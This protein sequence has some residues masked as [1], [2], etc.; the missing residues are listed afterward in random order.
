MGGVIQYYIRRL[1]PMFFLFMTEEA[2]LRVFLVLREFRQ[3]KKDAGEVFL[4]FATG[5]LFDAGIFAC[6][7]IPLAAY[8]AALPWRLHGTR[9]DRLL[10]GGLYFFMIYLMLFT[11]VAEW[12]FWDEFSSRFNFVAVDYLVYV[13]E[14]IGNIRE[15]YP[16][17]RLLSGIG[18]SA[19]LLTLWL[20]KHVPPA[21]AAAARPVQRLAVLAVPALT[22]VLSLG[23]LDHKMAEFG[24][25]RYWQEISRNGYYEISRA[26]LATD[27]PYEESY[28]SG[29]PAAALDRTRKKIDPAAAFTEDG[30]ARH[31]GASGPEKPYNIMLVTVESLSGKYLTDS[32]P[33]GYPLMPHINEIAAGSLFF[34]NF[35]ATG[36]RTVYGLSALTL[37][38]PP[39]PGNAIM[40]RTGSGGIFSLGKV[41][42]RKGY[43]RNFIYGGYGSFDKMNAFFGNNGYR[44]IDRSGFSGK[45]ITFSNTWGV[46]DEDLFARAIREG[47]DAY[48]EGRPFFNMLMT[49]SNHRPY[50]YP[51]GKINF[52]S[53]DG[54]R[55]GAVKY[56]DYAI[57]R[58]IAEAGKK[59]WFDNTLFVIVADH[60]A[61]SGGKKSLDPERYRVPLI[62][63][64]PAILSPQKIDG[65]ASQIDVAPT[66]LGLM[67]M[68]YTSRFYGADI[69]KEPPDRAYISTDRKLGYM[70]RD[71][72]VILEPGKEITRYK[73]A[74]GGLTKKETDGSDDE[75][76][77]DAIATFQTASRWKQLSRDGQ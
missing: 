74:G 24:D 77:K 11:G 36:T 30:I 56:T 53:G 7:V 48:R 19:L 8:L 16:V 51:D 76:V 2:V 45:E 40:R 58:L 37:S 17:G 47:D 20:L 3:L 70:T 60:A 27:L 4:C 15:S 5:V 38:I 39:I 41:L 35:Y 28:A 18:V 54:G 75:R 23:L 64:A 55:P 59:P 14:V 10:C 34:T 50:T 66:L 26:F 73:R 22:A 69:M 72:L 63:Y 67:N 29:D 31:I 13:R 57:G 68:S 71:A 1:M 33:A 44:V 49:T 52:P 6:F 25:N 43:V 62:I 61:R 46:C 21:G 42:G 65:L 12:I 9:T 32:A